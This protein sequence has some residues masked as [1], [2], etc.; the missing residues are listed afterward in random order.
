MND[1]SF[2]RLKVEER[3]KSRRRVFALKQLSNALSESNL[4][5]DALKSAVRIYNLSITDLVTTSAQN[6]DW[7]IDEGDLTLEAL[8][9][10]VFGLIDLANKVHLEDG[11]ALLEEVDA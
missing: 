10:K 2:L 6:I 7:K 8:K 1:E 9:L 3:V 5:I 11:Q 4:S